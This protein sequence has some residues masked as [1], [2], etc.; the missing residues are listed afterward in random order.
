M[1]WSGVLTG[2]GLAGTLDEILLHQLLGWHHFYDKSTPSVGLASDGLLHMFS[3]GLLA[4][5]LILIFRTRRPFGGFPATRTWA[6]ILLGA[7]GFNLYDGTVQ[8]KLLTLHQVREGAADQLPYD[9]GFIGIALAVLLAGIL[10][11]R[12]SNRMRSRQLGSPLLRPPRRIA[13]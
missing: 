10:L 11:Q 6:G 7:G 4:L 3:T 12:R 5:G 9:A 2:I 8:H 13:Q 1:L